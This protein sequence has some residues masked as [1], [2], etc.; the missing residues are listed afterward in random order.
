MIK[1]NKLNCNKNSKIINNHNN[2]LVNKQRERVDNKSKFSDVNNMKYDDKIK[3]LK[4]KLN[5]NESSRLSNKLNEKKILGNKHIA[6]EISKCDKL[7]KSKFSELNGIKINRLSNKLSNK[8]KNI[9][10]NNILLNKTILS[11]NSNDII[12]NE[13]IVKNNKFSNVKYNALSSVLVISSFFIFI[14]IISL[15]GISAQTPV[16]TPNEVS[17]C[18]EKTLSGA[19]CQNAPREQC[20]TSPK[21]T[22]EPY[23]IS[24]TSCDSTSYCQKGCCYDGK[25][26]ICMENT[27]KEACKKQNGAWSDSATCNTPQCELGCCVLGEQA[28]Y[29]PLVRCK[30]LASLYG[31]QVDFKKEIKNE[32]S[33]IN[34]AQ[35]QDVGACVYESEFESTCKF[36]TRGEC[37]AGKLNAIGN[38]SSIRF[39]KDYLCTAPELNTIC[40]PLKETTCAAGKDGVYFK[41]SCGN[42]ANIYDA[43]MIYENN[44]GSAAVIQYWSKVIKKEESCGKG[45]ANVNS[46]TCGNCDYLSG[47]TCGIAEGG[48]SP[49]YGNYICQDLNCKKTSNGK[50]YKNGESWCYYDGGKE[51]GANV[52]SR[53]Y[54]HICVMGEETVEPCE[55]FRNEVCTE[56]KIGDGKFSQAGCTVNKWQDCL[57]QKRANDCTNTDRRDCTW[58]PVAKDVKDF[59]KDMKDKLKDGVT[60][61]LTNVKSN[62]RDQGVC[63]PEIA[64]GIKFWGDQAAVTHCDIVS[65]N[66]VVTYE[67]SP[68]GGKKCVKNC[69]CENQAVALQM[70][71]ICT[72]IGDCGPKSNYVDKFSRGGYE[73]VIKKG[74]TGSELQLGKFDPS[75]TKGGQAGGPAAPGPAV[76]SPPPVQATQS[77]F[78]ANVNRGQTFGGSP[79]ANAAGNTP[80]TPTTTSTPAPPGPTGQVIQDLVVDSYNKVAGQI[81]K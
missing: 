64:P 50:D 58:I 47:S 77:A 28:A 34:L 4:N 49:Q 81:K 71:N 24:P 51:K 35:A 75:L 70:I 29:V 44:K 12:V 48:N 18:C 17:Y 22:G 72:K 80:T 25:E 36:T 45:G 32:L 7:D 66:C 31:L 6:N 41:D 16:N 63:V 33:C 61:L 27:P 15:V 74:A 2:T 13:K 62:D 30:K 5:C 67:K 39:H 54:R 76:T 14:L 26:G 23:S 68:I 19:Y 52:G 8:I 60:G 38:L 65:S 53:N 21:S 56:N 55:D 73:V 3:G 1:S 9:N 42:T 11:E 37:Q 10:Y 40:Q 78:G 69:W 20:D 79:E 43:S 59:G 46:K 57:F